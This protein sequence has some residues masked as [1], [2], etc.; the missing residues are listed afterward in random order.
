QPVV[1]IPV[2]GIAHCAIPPPPRASIRRGSPLGAGINPHP[3]PLLPGERT[4]VRALPCSGSLAPRA[5]PSQEQYE[6]FCPAAYVES[7]WLSTALAVS[8][9]D[10]RRMRY[11]GA[12]GVRYAGFP[13]GRA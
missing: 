13:E 2:R 12:C 8:G 6:A 3:F 4:S 1:L 5:R 10:R 7:T 11:N 9:E